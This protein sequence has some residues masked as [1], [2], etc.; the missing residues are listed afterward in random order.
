MNI[1]CVVQEFNQM[2][3]PSHLTSWMLS[4]QGI[5]MEDLDACIC[6]SGGLVAIMSSPMYNMTYCPVP[7]SYGSKLS[8]YSS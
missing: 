4:S 8:N 1:H 3:C 6:A 2:L 7:S 5:S